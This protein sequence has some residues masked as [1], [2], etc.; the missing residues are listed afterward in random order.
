MGPERG[1]LPFQALAR[2]RGI[3][4]LSRVLETLVLPLH[5]VRKILHSF[6]DAWQG[7]RLLKWL[8]PSG[9]HAL[10]CLVLRTGIE[11]VLHP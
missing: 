1:F 10:L 9:L 4:P 6:T 11:P 8:P 7:L 3:E 2:P 5:H